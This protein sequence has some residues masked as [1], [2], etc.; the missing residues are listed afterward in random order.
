MK[1]YVKIGPERYVHEDSIRIR[2]LYVKSIDI[3]LK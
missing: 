2:R 1:S 3:S